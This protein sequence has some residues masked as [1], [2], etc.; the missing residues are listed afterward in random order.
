MNSHAALFTACLGFAAIS[1]ALYYDTLPYAFD[2]FFRILLDAKE[3]AQRWGWALRHG[4]PDD[5]L[6]SHGSP[7][8]HWRRGVSLSCS[9]WEGVVP[10]RYGRQA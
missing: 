6:L 1:E 4:V 10:P 7:H 2:V 8:Y 9:G 3:N 5:D